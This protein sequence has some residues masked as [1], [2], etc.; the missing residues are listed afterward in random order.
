MSRFEISAAVV[1]AHALPFLFLAF[2]IYQVCTCIPLILRSFRNAW[3]LRT[4]HGIGF[5]VTCVTGVTGLV[6]LGSGDSVFIEFME[7]FERLFFENAFFTSF[8]R[9][10]AT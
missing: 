7:M 10:F 3:K 5:A 2:S 8:A 1:F 6:A 9:G 4:V